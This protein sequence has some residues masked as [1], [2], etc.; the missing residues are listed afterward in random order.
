[1]QR[2]RPRGGRSPGPGPGAPIPEVP[3]ELAELDAL[4]PESGDA[5]GR[6]V[7]PDGGWGPVVRVAGGLPGETVRVV[8]TGGRARLLS[9]VSAS[10][11]RVVPTCPHAGVCGGC[12]WQHLAYPEQLAWKQ[13]R[14]AELL[15]RATGGPVHVLPTL[16]SPGGPPDLGGAAPP[17]G[18]DPAAPWGVRNKVHFVAGSGQR[19]PTLGHYQRGTQGLVPIEVC[20]IHDPRGNRLAFAARDALA[21]Q[22][23]PGVDERELARGGAG[24]KFGAV[25]HV[26]AR[27]SPTTG[28]A[29]LTLV[30]TSDR[31][32]GLR[33][34]VADLVARD[35]APDGVHLNVHDGAGPLILGGDGR[36]LHGRERH[37]EEVSGVRYLVSS[38]AFFQTNVRAAA[39]LVEAVLAR[40]PADG[41]PVLDLFAGCGLFSLPLA[42]RGHR[43]LGVEES[44]SAVADAAASR[45]AS[46]LEGADVRVA[47]ERAEVAVRKL[48][49]GEL[50][51]DDVRTV[52]IDPPRDG[53]A[54]G[55]LEDV[56]QGLRPARVLYVSCNPD[57]LA[58]DAARAARVGW[59]VVE[60]QP[61]DMF[62]QTPH[63]ET[64]A[65]LEPVGREA[66][67]PEGR[68]RR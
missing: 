24:P 31:V 17:A 58:A 61:V 35:E 56:L 15:A 47:R 20:P 5:V 53:C 2:R 13:A 4:D 22:R 6:V 14:V 11:K 38:G 43:V 63:I 45:R 44:P 36:K 16:A 65:L 21:K 19:G 12:A 60:A 40:I 8:R 26:L 3:E 66:A 32:K 25:R 10:S 27:T 48:L 30:T 68:G 29:L 62:P 37:L 67:S 34:A 39:L 54:P 28:Q 33:E 55:L 7:L 64:V 18:A 50:R 9:V 59:R 23:V 49:S 41:R 1:M 42:R 51:F 46:E 57:A 52:V